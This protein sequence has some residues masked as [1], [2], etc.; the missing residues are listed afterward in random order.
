MKKRILSFILALVVMMSFTQVT[1][2]AASGKFTYEKTDKSKT[3]KIKKGKIHEVWFFKRV[4]MPGTSAF[5]KKLNRLFLNESK[6][7]M[8]G[9]GVMGSAKSSFGPG[10]VFYNT[11]IQ[12]GTHYSDRF[13]SVYSLNT[14][15]LKN[16]IVY[17]SP[18]GYTYD[19]K[20]G[21]KIKKITDLTKERSF[22]KVRNT[23]K[24]KVEKTLGYKVDDYIDPM[25]EKDFEDTFFLTNKGNVSVGFAS[26]TGMTAKYVIVTIK[27]RY[28]K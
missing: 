24:K 2:V 18:G 19:R 20:T 10:A 23:I 27:G 9:K 4:I 11:M 3:Y 8:R 15:G 1:S 13:I 14:Y 17:K 5:E 6:K 28:A 7:F 16:A 21:K 25:K 12:K 22:K 26:Y